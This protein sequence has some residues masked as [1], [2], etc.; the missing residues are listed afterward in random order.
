MKNEK[1]TV[2]PSATRDLGAAG[3]SRS[4]ARFARIRM[5]AVAVTALVGAA[6]CQKDFLTENPS[7]FVSPTN[8]Y[9]NQADALSALTS[10]YATFVDLPSPLGN[11]AYFGRNL[12]MLIEYPTEVTTSRLSA[13][14]RPTTSLAYM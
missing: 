10:A 11:A 4:Y 9:R 13:R 5:T 6:A 7:D 1:N 12:L 2:I 3:K 8:F 14:V